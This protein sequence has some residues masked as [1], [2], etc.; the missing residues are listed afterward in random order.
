ML[1]NFPSVHRRRFRQLLTSLASK[2]TYLARENECKDKAEREKAVNLFTHLHPLRSAKNLVS[3]HKSTFETWRK[4][5]PRRPDLYIISIRY[6]TTC[7]RALMRAASRS[8]RSV[9]SEAKPDSRWWAPVNFAFEIAV[10]I[11]PSTKYIPKCD[12]LISNFNY[13]PR[14]LPRDGLYT[15]CH[16]SCRDTN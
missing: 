15:D 9:N 1:Y 2:T 16:A 8:R 14:L 10:A 12:K 5:L 4:I 11:P 13:S 3:E 6:S 7:E